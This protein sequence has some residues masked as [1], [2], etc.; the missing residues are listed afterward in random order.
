[1]AKNIIIL[2]LILGFIG[3]VIFLDI[4]GVQNTLRL[5]EQIKEQKKLF[6]EKQDLLH[7]IEDLKK[8]YEEHQE[9]LEKTDYILPVGG[10]VPNLIVQLEALALEGGLVLEDVSF[11]VYKEEVETRTKEVP[12]EKEK[13]SKDYQALLINLKLIGDYP[14][15]KNFLKAVEKNIRLIDIISVNFSSKSKEQSSLFEFNLSVKTYHQ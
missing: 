4:P 8:N 2:T 6:S 1:M 7:K 10:D 14:A 3:I 11:S 9:N 13:T 15:F 5:R 12:E